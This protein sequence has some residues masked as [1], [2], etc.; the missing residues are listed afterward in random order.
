M[1]K[2][3][4]EAVLAVKEVQQDVKKFARAEKD[5]RRF[6]N[7]SQ[8]YRISLAVKL[9]AVF[10]LVKT[11]SDDAAVSFLKKHCVSSNGRGL[12]GVFGV[13]D[14]QCWMH[15]ASHDRAFQAA[16][17]NNNHHIAVSANKHIAEYQT[18]NDIFE[19]NKR[20]IPVAS[21]D[22]LE[23]YIANIPLTG[24]GPKM[25]AHVAS[26]SNR[27]KKKE[28]WLQRFRTKWSLEYRSLKARKHVALK[29][30]QK[31]ATA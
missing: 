27:K 1:D 11:N 12:S 26:I 2:M 15:T 28:R 17:Q 14:V 7:Q 18:Y 13:E 4:T 8:H 30:K 29:L 3:I 10:I 24:R 22:I 16:E 5:R 19:M 21:K 6:S 23:G 25:L 20:G 9:V 31:Q